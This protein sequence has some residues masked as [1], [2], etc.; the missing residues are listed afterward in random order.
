MKKNKVVFKGTEI[1]VQ[2]VVQI[3][4]T[5]MG[6][7]HKYHKGKY[8]KRRWC[9]GISQPCEHKCFIMLVDKRDEA[10]LL[11]MNDEPNSEM[12]IVSDGWAAYNNLSSAG[13][14]H[15]TVIHKTEF[16]NKEEQT[17]NSIE[18]VWFQFKTWINAMHELRKGYYKDY[19]DE[20][21]FRYNMCKGN[22]NDCIEPFLA[23]LRH[24]QGFKVE[25]E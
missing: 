7:A 2:D 20:F 11:N 3:D 6:K 5:S 25:D 8:T 24:Y 1:S 21:M 13:Y 18:S 22:R 17:T 19:M 16:K 15:S 9:F 10:T 23:H 4:E 14:R 12:H